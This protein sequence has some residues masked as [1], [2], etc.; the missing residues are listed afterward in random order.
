MEIIGDSAFYNCMALEHVELPE[1]LDSV[2][3]RTFEH[4]VRLTDLPDLRD[5]IEE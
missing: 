2:G 1:D 3:P 5:L 4:C